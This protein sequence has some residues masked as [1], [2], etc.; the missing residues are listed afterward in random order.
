[1][2]GKLFGSVAAPNTGP[3]TGTLVQFGQNAY[4]V[5]GSAAS[6]SMDGHGFAYVPASCAAGA[7]CRLMVALHGCDQGYSEVGTAFVDRA[8]LDQ[9]AATNDMIVLYPQAVPS[10]VNPLGCWDWWGYLGAT[11]YPIKGGAQ[12]ETIMNMV[13]ALGG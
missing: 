2:L 5:G 12:I 9:Y 7:S 6:L 3:L 8:N 4:A 11:N 10:A 13:S 1:M